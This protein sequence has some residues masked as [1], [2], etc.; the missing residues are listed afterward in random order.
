MTEV[1]QIYDYLLPRMKKKYI[2]KVAVALPL[3]KEEREE[4]SPILQMLKE[5]PLCKSETR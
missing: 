3:C 4:R 1:S 5:K 2:L